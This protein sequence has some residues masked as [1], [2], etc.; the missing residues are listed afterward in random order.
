M[1]RQPESILNLEE[2]VL[3]FFDYAKDSVTHVTLLP[4]DELQMVL[5]DTEKMSNP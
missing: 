2:T 5:T 1:L 3:R 4:L